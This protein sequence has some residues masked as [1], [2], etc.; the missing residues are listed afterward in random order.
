VTR[1]TT[2][3]AIVDSHSDASS[4]SDPADV[5]NAGT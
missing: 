5:M 4:L 3:A 1:I 2:T